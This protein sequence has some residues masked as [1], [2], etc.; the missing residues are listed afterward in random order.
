M[1]TTLTAIR[2]RPRSGGAGAARRCDLCSLA[3]GL[4]CERQAEAA[5]AALH[6]MAHVHMHAQRAH[7]TPRVAAAGNNGGC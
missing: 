2:A 3:G 4:A 1:R 7:D 6:H 5:A